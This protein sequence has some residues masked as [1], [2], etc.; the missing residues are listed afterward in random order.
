L[1]QRSDA[2]QG[3]EVQAEVSLRFERAQR[4]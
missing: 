4:F 1:F 3:E 2:G